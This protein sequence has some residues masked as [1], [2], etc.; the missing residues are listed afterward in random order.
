M[1]VRAVLVRCPWA[2][3]PWAYSSLETETPFDGECYYTTIMLEMTSPTPRT[4]VLNNKSDS[5]HPSGRAL[6]ESVAGDGF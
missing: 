3:A 4:L 1:L 6:N 2:G 5:F